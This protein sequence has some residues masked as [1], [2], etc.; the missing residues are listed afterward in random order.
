MIESSNANID[1]LVVHQMGAKSAGGV[2]RLAKRPVDISTGGDVMVD[3]LKTF[4]FKSFKTEAYYTFDTEII[5]QTDIPPVK[6]ICESLFNG[7]TQ[8]YDSSVAIASRLFECSNHPNIRGGE[9]YVVHF[10]DVVVDGEICDAIG[11]FKSENK[12]TFIRINFGIDSEIQL[13]AQEGIS[14]KKIDKGCIIFNIEQESGYRICAVDNINK[15]NEAHFWVEDFL[16]LQ[17]REDNYFFT[18]NYMQM[19]RGFVKDV[20]NEENHVPRT[21]QMD[22]VNRT[23][24]FFEN[25]PEFSHDEFA[26]NV[27]EK[28]DL[29]DAFN[30]YKERFEVEHDLPQPLPESFHVSKDAVKGEKKNFKSILKLDKNFHIYVHG[31]RYYMEK[32]FDEQKDLNYYKLYFKI[33][34]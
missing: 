22:L 23:M 24:S 6:D 1:S 7:R 19:C 14:V 8:F 2:L 9:I 17:P 18:D 29:I 33:E 20:Y 26:K 25:T 10:T 4:F 5:N 3:V 28:P 16:G 15:G 11:I 30:E 31:G 21:D 27:V 12:E 13:K 34:Q 32:G